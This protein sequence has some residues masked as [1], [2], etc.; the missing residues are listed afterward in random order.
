MILRH[1]CKGLL[2]YQFFSWDFELLTI[3]LEYFF[4]EDSYLVGKL[5]H[6]SQI[7][8]PLLL[9]TNCHK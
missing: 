4:K 2:E 7:N 6:H 5:R 3:G 1:P 8:T 9:P